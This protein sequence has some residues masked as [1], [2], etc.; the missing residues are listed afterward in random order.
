ML[1]KTF[2]IGDCEVLCVNVIGERV[3]FYDQYFRLSYFPCKF[4]EVF[5]IS[6]EHT[7]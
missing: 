7:T 2:T 5:E 3:Y 6:K 1:I 4:P